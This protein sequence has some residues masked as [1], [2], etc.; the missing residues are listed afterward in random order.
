MEAN[1]GKIESATEEVRIRLRTGVMRDLVG[2]WEWG[3]HKGLS[4]FCRRSAAALV[5]PAS[6]AEGPAEEECR[7]EGPLGRLC[8]MGRL[9]GELGA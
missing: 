1:L 2:C 7:E 3:L 6:T 9:L 4:A 8:T 5:P